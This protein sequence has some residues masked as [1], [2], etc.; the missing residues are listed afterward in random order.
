MRI[1]MSPI[2]GILLLLGTT[3]IFGASL[4]AE[5]QEML[6]I[7]PT[8]IDHLREGIRV[9]GSDELKSVDSRT[10]FNIQNTIVPMAFSN[11]KEMKISVS[12]GQLLLLTYIADVSVYS[13]FLIRKKRNVDCAMEY[14]TYLFDSIRN[15]KGSAEVK[16]WIGPTAPEVFYGTQ[17]GRCKKWASEFP[18]VKELRTQRDYELNT[19]L[20]FIYLH[21]LGHLNGTDRHIDFSPLERISIYDERLR[22][23]VELNLM[24]REQEYRAD[25]WAVDRFVEMWANPWVLFNMTTIN[26]FLAF[27]GIDCGLDDARTHPSGLVRVAKISKRLNEEIKKKKRKLAAPQ[28]SEVVDDLIGMAK[29]AQSKLDCVRR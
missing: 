19:L 21:E 3:R 27:G 29:E 2:W 22:K 6:D 14:V 23:F 12:P 4:D 1:Y 7:L 10:S 8:K 16:K 15:I 9:Y 5:Y 13:N 11:L 25:E 26:Y 28:M 20:Y 17:A 18:L 24:S